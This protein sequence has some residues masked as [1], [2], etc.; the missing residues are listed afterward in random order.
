MASK[1]K[2]VEN[3]HSLIT[4]EP[5]FQIVDED[6]NMVDS[7]PRSKKDAE[8][9]LK[10]LEPAKEEKKAAPPKKAPAKKTATKKK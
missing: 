8:A 1:Y 2:L 6:G 3:G 5:L 7:K 10:S 4:M 9:A